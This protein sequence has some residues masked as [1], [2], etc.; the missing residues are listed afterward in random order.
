MTLEKESQEKDRVIENLEEIVL[1][2]KDVISYLDSI[3]DTLSDMLDCMEDY[4][5]PHARH[6][7]YEINN[8]DEY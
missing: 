2:A 5:I 3:N 7:T 6:Y 1:N 4:E 8:N